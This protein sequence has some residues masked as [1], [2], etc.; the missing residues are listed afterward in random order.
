MSTYWACN[1]RSIMDGVISLHEQR[2]SA[3][4]EIPVE[5]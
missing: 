5:L 1:I 4:I 3:T 2:A